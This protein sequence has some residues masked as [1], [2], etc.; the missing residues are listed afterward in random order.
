MGQSLSSTMQ[1]SV[2]QNAGKGSTT[3]SATSGQ[4][5]MGLPN[6]NIPQTYDN[7]LN[8]GWD[9][10]QF[11]STSTSGKGQGKGG[12]ASNQYTPVQQQAAQQ[13]I[14]QYTGSHAF[15]NS[16][17]YGNS[18]PNGTA[19]TFNNPFQYAVGKLSNIALGP[20]NPAQV[21]VSDYSD[22]SGVGG[23]GYSMNNGLSSMAGSTPS[24]SQM[25]AMA[26]ANPNGFGYSGGSG[27]D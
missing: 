5:Q 17:S 11:G 24:E 19:Y 25:S 8:G 18:N 6:R 2:P 16:M 9:N 1:S 4:P 14:Q 23:G 3:N 26:A 15:D 22:Y 27:S 20:Q 7:T 12:A 21:P 13:P 10:A